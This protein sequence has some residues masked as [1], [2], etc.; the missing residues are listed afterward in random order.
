[1]AY[2]YTL[3]YGTVS[4]GDAILAA[5]HN[6]THQEHIDS[7]IPENI[8]DYS[9]SAAEMR[10]TADP[11]PGSTESLATT[12]AGEIERLRYVLKQITGGTYWYTDPVGLDSTIVSSSLTSVGTIGTGVW[13][14][15]SIGTSYTDAKVTSVS[16]STG[17]VVDGD[18]DH[19]A[20]ANFASNEHFT[21][22]NITATGTVASGVWNGTSIG[23]A[24]TDAKVTSVSGSTGAVT[25]GDIDHDSL[26]NFASNEHYTQAN[27]TATGTVASGTWQGTAIDG[28]YIDLEGTEVK[29]TGEGGGSKYL[30]E[31]GDGTCSWQTVAGGVTS[32]SGA[33]GAVADGDIDHD[34]LANFA[35]NEHF[36]QA[37]ITATGTIAS[38]T[39]NGTSISTTYT[40]AKLADVADDTSPTLGGTLDANGNSI[41]NASTI[42]FGTGVNAHF[43]IPNSCFINIDSDNDGADDGRFVVSKNNTGTSGTELFRVQE[44]GK[45]GIGTNS[46]DTGLHLYQ[47]DTDTTT[48]SML[49]EQEGTGDASLT[50]LLTGAQTWSTGIDNSNSNA[51][52][53]SVAADL[54]SSPRMT[55]EVGGNVGIGT[56]SPLSKLTVADASAMISLVD[57]D[58]AGSEYAAVW[59]DQEGN[60]FLNADV[61]GT[62]S[63][64]FISFRTGGVAAGDEV[65]RIAA[66]G[67]VGIGT[68]NP[69]NKLAVNGGSTAYNS[70]SAAL[71]L[72]GTSDKQMLLGYDESADAAFIG[73][74]DPTVAWKN[75]ALVQANVGISTTSPGQILDVN[76]GS[77]NAIADGWSTHSLAV[78]KEDIEDAS[79]YLA[80]VVA[81][82]AQTWRRKPFVSADEIKDAVLNEFGDDVLVEEAVEAK[83]A[84]LDDDGNILEPLVE[85]KEAVFE[86][87][88]SAWD[89]L[90]PG[91]ASHRNKAL[92]NM[93]DGELKTWIDNWCESKRVEMRPEVKW[94]KK[95]VGLV[96]DA[97]LTAK[98]LPEVISINDEG[99][100][101]G[102]DT[103]AYIGVL[104]NAIQELSAK[105]AALEAKC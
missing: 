5:H 46:V 58:R 14:G 103:M 3:T 76:S 89:D 96:A 38:G 7:N 18:I 67:K 2:P 25:D 101:T 20:L 105:V 10:T 47:N 27:I 6:T 36:T 77:G 22:A 41:T 45:V 26:A 74:L 95:Q 91:G 55:I 69:S 43:D 62:S 50:Y 97:E 30:R 12:L 33:T 98:H 40:D 64:G 61:D 104:H 34:Q 23:T 21:Q 78:Y 82:P 92:Y 44:D 52:Q 85:A 1:M 59:A 17:A 37:N 100:T 9:V 70:G 63:S 71:S 49:I 31:D 19:D 99:D 53:I 29:S 72:F 94:Q 39:W 48:P 93:P 35:S 57:T 15:T 13:Q 80:K 11:Y 54:G 65:V 90:F 51:Y 56:T 73:A 83:E 84:I 88:Y 86:K 87:R 8:D 75:I 42:A 4:A 16:G 68:T 81:C 102:I 66:D 32:V 28:T 79:G 24:Y 60:L